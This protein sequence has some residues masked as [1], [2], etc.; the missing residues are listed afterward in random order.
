MFVTE[1]IERACCKVAPDAMRDPEWERSRRVGQNQMSIILVLKST[2]F[3]PRNIDPY[4]RSSWGSARVPCTT[5][6]WG[7]DNTKQSLST[8]IGPN[9]KFAKPGA[10]I[11]Y[12]K[13]LSL[14]CL[15]QEANSILTRRV[16]WFEGMKNE[17]IWSRSLQLIGSQTLLFGTQKEIVCISDTLFPSFQ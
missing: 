11:L 8:E 6:N 4:R 3:S 10:N 13:V 17:K 1:T 9:N 15:L 5:K 7:R 12:L 14:K 2:L 16:E